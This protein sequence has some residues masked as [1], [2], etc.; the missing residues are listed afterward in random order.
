MILHYIFYIIL[1]YIQF[2]WCIGFIRFIAF[3][4]LKKHVGF[5]KVLSGLG[6]QS[7]HL[8]LQQVE[9]VAHLRVQQRPQLNDV[10]RRD[11]TWHDVTRRDTTWPL[12]LNEVKKI[13]SRRDT[14]NL[15]PKRIEK[16]ILGQ[17]F[18]GE[19]Y[20]AIFIHCYRS[21]DNFQANRALTNRRTISTPHIY[22]ITAVSEWLNEN[23][24]HIAGSNS[25]SSLIPL[26][27]HLPLQL[28][29]TSPRAQLCQ[30]V[31]GSAQKSR[32][33][34][35]FVIFVIFAIFLGNGYQQETTTHKP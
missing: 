6:A 11:T 7:L 13:E 15:E 21:Y 20:C 14:P 35:I 19:R 1:L 26:S 31:A 8:G 23:S 24:C 5:V 29:Q 25:Y 3:F 2:A 27:F 28:Q 33:V 32:T 16:L 9:L 12:T 30:R 22:F 17:I 10:T 4:R 18:Q 34:A